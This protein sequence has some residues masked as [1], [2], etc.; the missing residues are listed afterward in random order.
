MY[1]SLNEKFCA[2][3]S[4]NKKTVSELRSALDSALNSIDDMDKSKDASKSR[5]YEIINKRLNGK[6][7]LSEV[8]WHNIDCLFDEVYPHFKEQIYGNHYVDEREYRMCMLIKLGLRNIDI[9]LL[10]YR[11]KGSISSARSMLYKKFFNRKGS[12]QEFNDFIKSL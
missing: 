6:K 8:E 4:N 2:E 3:R 1:N 7:G 5:I 10:M 9:S 12:A 11:T